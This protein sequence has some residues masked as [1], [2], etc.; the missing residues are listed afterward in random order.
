MR[1]NFLRIMCASVCVIF[2]LSLTAC[3]GDSGSKVDNRASTV[4]PAF[5]EAMKNYDNSTEK[6]TTYA[7]DVILSIYQ[8]YQGAVTPIAAIGEV[9]VTR[10]RSQDKIYVE[11]EIDID[12][13]SDNR[14]ESLYRT[15]RNLVTT[16][17]DPSTDNVDLFLSGQ[18]AYR[19]KLG[20]TGSVYN[21]KAGYYQKSGSAVKSVWLA[22]DKE[23]LPHFLK[24][25]GIDLEMTAPELLMANALSELGTPQNWSKKDSADKYFDTSKNHFLYAFS[26]DR[27]KM[28]RILFDYLGRLVSAVEG[29]RPLA[30]YAD[31]Y[32]DVLPY[33]QKWINVGNSSVNADVNYG[34][35][36]DAITTDLRVS[37]DIPYNDLCEV[38][39][40][41]IHDEKDQPDAFDLVSNLMNV[42][43]VCGTSGQENT[44]GLS[45]D[46]K[47]REKIAYGKS[48]AALDKVDPDLF[49][50]LDEN[51]KDRKVYL[52]SAPQD[53]DEPSSED[54]SADPG[55]DDASSPSATLSDGQTPLDA[56]E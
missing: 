26:L 33:L 50:P 51:K 45:I 29:V 46:V 49:L 38:L 42:L 17:Y 24:S 20:Y 16:D 8:R 23:S 27:E 6:K 11:T 22:T 40:Y 34:K 28:Q 31:A 1:K 53:P 19:A 30:D 44:I 55:Q 5:D 48:N 18:T 36:P 37:A 52:Y 41:F 56:E 39:R 10:V 13:D 4:K 25:Q 15:F 7:A 2:L 12:E 32:D 21:L 54:N 3:F 43:S 9:A 14:V 35:Y 47:V